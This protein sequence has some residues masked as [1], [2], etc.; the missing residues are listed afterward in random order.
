MSDSK[1]PPNR[2]VANPSWVTRPETSFKHTL[3]R[4]ISNRSFNDWY[5]ER[6]YEENIL[7]GRP[8]FNGL[9]SPPPAEKHTPSKLLQCHRKVAYAPENAPREE[10]SPDGLFWTG[11]LLI[12]R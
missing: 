11:T 1:G 12:L 10:A 6:E 7:Q 5:N 4:S 3:L 9:S 2:I 8:Y